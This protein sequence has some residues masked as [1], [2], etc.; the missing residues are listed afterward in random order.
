[1]TQD[2]E[3]AR[4][5]KQ[6][7]DLQDKVS[8]LRSSNG[9]LIADGDRRE[10]RALAL[11]P[12]CEAHRRELQYLRHCV[13]W[14]WHS[15][16]DSDEARRAIV[17]QLGNVVL[18][19]RRGGAETLKAA[20]VADWLDKAIDKQKRPLNRHDYPTLADCL[21]AGGCSHDGLCDD[22]VADIAEALGL[23]PA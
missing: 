22:V 18:G 8:Q 3:I 4:L 16:N 20:D 9:A 13:S 10:Q 5:R 14:Y 23:V 19:I 11:L 7:A 12:D 21:R 15:M 1:M 6:V 17:G 2:E